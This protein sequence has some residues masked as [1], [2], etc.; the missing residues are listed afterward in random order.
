MELFPGM[1]AG[2]VS[3]DS[4]SL[5]QRYYS[6]WEL[7]ALRHTK[8]M[9]LSFPWKVL[10]RF[11]S[12]ELTAHEL[13]GVFVSSCGLIA[14]SFIPRVCRKPLRRHQDVRNGYHGQNRA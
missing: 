1:A 14:R 12:T 6:Q 8:L 11:G 7:V 5:Q 3:I 4:C 9:Y 13:T 10:V 2:F